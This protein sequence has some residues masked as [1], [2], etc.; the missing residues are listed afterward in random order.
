VSPARPPSRSTGIAGLPQKSEECGVDD[1]LNEFDGTQRIDVPAATR[2][3][4]TLRTATSL[5]DRLRAGNAAPLRTESLGASDLTPDGGNPGFNVASSAIVSAIDH[6]Q[7]WKTLISVDLHRFPLPILSHFTLAR[8]VYEPSMFTLW[9]LDPTVTRRDR[10]GRGYAVQLQSL[11][12]MNVYQRSAGLTPS[13]S[14]ASALHARLLAAARRD[15]FVRGGRSTSSRRL[16]PPLTHPVPS[17]SELFDMYDQPP[18]SRAAQARVRFNLMS[19]LAHSRYWAIAGTAADLSSVT[20]E[21]YRLQINFPLACDIAEATVAIASRA[22]DAFNGYRSGPDPV[23]DDNADDSRT[24]ECEVCQSG[25][26]DAGTA[27]TRDGGDLRVCERCAATTGTSE[28]WKIRR[29]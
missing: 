3:R 4:D 22:V 1:A 14:N 21:G 11:D 18:A 9:L 5:A 25:L 17:I 7:T 8:A 26:A 28:N 2:L 10:I 12:D 23:T 29:S 15:G 16:T 19:G 6:L 20:S 13:E 27:R 24:D